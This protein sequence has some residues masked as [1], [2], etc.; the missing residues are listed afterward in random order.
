VVQI[1]CGNFNW[2]KVH[3]LDIGDSCKKSRNRSIFVFPCPYFG[4]YSFCISGS[5]KLATTPNF[6]FFF[7]VSC[8]HSSHSTDLVGLTVRNTRFFMVLKFPRHRWCTRDKFAVHVFYC[9]FSSCC[10]CLLPDPLLKM[11]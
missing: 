1:Q 7:L 10:P 4:A 3:N 8:T 6:F 9:S 11:Y 5:W 2:N